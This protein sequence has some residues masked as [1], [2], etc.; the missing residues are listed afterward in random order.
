MKDGAVKD[1][2]LNSSV[3]TYTHTQTFAKKIQYEIKY[4]TKKYRLIQNLKEI[5]EKRSLKI[6]IKQKK[7]KVTEVIQTMQKLHKTLMKST[8]LKRNSL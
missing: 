4:N 2:D 7:I 8:T 5:K 1:I 3:N 6:E